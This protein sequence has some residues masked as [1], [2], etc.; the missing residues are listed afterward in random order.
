MQGLVRSLCG[1]MSPQ[2]DKWQLLDQLL[3]E[4]DDLQRAQA[5]LGWD[6]QTYMPSAGGGP[7]GQQLATLG[8]ITHERFTSRQI[9]DLLDELGA[10]VAGRPPEDEQSALIRATR[11]QYDQMVKIP[12]DLVQEW[13]L[14]SASAYDSWREARTARDFRHYAAAF[15]RILGLMGQIADALGYTGER[16]DALLD[17]GE[18]GMTSAK[19]EQVFAE[20]RGGLVP[21]VRAIGEHSDRV[22]NA[23][24]CQHYDGQKQWDLGIEA[25][26]AIGFDFEHGR[27]DR[28]VHPFTTSFGVEDVRITTRIDEEYFPMGFYGTMHEA[29]HGLYEL[30]LPRRWNRTPLGQ[31]VS[32]G[33]HESQSR[34]W[35]NIIGRSRAFWQFFLPRLQA[36]FPAQTGGASVEEIYRAV[37]KSEPSLIRVEADEVTYNLHIMVR[38]EVERALMRGDLKVQDIPSAWAEK[39]RDYLGV[40]PPDDLQGALQDIHWTG[41]IGSFIGYTIGNVI[42]AQLW[43]AIGQA[44]PHPEQHVARGDFAPILGWLRTN[45]HGQGATYE[46][47]ELLRR[48]TGSGLTA[49]PYLAYIQG[50]YTELYGL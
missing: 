36:Y 38:F 44:I 14:A 19:A 33:V 31:A 1:E 45:I 46:V 22:S 24:V 20:L 21:I 18:P 47:E 16:Y 50:K 13:A 12:G 41:G 6:Q 15:S 8:R 3:G 5:V 37:N 26:T 9:G 7:R 27:Q 2:L 29:G 11:R 17:M 28:S 4:A 10:E 23:L 48:T 39:M 43:A 49:Q 34:F 30:G 25:I 32:S 42:S 40:T 35:E